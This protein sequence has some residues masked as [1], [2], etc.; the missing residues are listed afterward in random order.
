ME[1]GKPGKH[2][3]K[4]CGAQVSTKYTKR[5]TRY[6]VTHPNTK[7]MRFISEADYSKALGDDNIC[8]YLPEPFNKKG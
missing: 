6:V 4:F 8:A 1:I 2:L 3:R 5:G 7:M